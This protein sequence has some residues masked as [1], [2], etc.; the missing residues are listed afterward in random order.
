MEWF[1]PLIA[2]GA[3]FLVFLPI[4]IKI[5]NYKK[6]KSNCSCGCDCTSCNKDCL[7]HF[8][9]YLDNRK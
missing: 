9:K 4:I 1:E 2:I 7:K 5:Y 3:I 8:K 6:G